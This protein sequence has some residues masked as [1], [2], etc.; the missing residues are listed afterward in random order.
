MQK[1][2]PLCTVGENV[3]WCSHGK[4]IWRF[5]KNLNIE[6]PYDLAVLLLGIHPKELKIGTQK[7]ICM[8]MLRATLFTIAKMWKQA[9]CPRIDMN[10]KTG[11]VI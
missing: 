5:L 6:L 11:C 8:T 4:A 7:D 9:K 1:P 3:K 2:E 10:G